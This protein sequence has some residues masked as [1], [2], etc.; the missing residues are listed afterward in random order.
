MSTSTYFH[1]SR[2][3]Y[4]CKGWP[5]GQDGIIGHFSILIPSFNP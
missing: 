2:V 4:N 5:N 1:I 3:T